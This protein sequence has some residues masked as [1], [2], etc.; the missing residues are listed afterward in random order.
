MAVESP[1]SRDIAILHVGKVEMQGAVACRTFHSLRYSVE[2]GIDIIRHS[3]RA[4]AQISGTFRQRPCGIV[5]TVI[6]LPIDAKAVALKRI[7]TDQFR[8]LAGFGCVADVKGHFPL[9]FRADH[10]PTVLP[11][12]RTKRQNPPYCSAVLEYHG[13][14][15]AFRSVNYAS[16]RKIRKT[17]E[18]IL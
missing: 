6:P 4:Q 14:P 9:P 3:R 5:G 7:R 10:G 1:E 12:H 2:G 11:C 13:P 18:I 8:R 17:D 16:L 15:I